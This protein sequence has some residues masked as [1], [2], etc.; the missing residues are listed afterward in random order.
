MSAEPIPLRPSKIRCNECICSS[1]CLYKNLSTEGKEVWQQTGT[2]QPLHKGDVL[3]YQGAPRRTI[4]II[5]SGNVKEFFNTSAGHEQILGFYSGGSAVGLEISPAGTYQNTSVALDTSA[6]CQIPY[7]VALNLPDA[8]GSI[9]KHLLDLSYER[10]S[11]R[12]EHILTIGQKS[13]ISRLA[14][15]L[16]DIS[17]NLSGRGFSTNKFTL[18]MCRHDIAN[19]LALAVETVSRAFTDLESSGILCVNRKQVE[20]FEWDL[21]A[22]IASGADEELLE[23]MKGVI[24][25]AHR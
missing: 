10:L 17:A 22:S 23:D 18:A 8:G 6:V 20:I 4:S 25:M 21:L 13:A 9:Q 12:N 19:Y 2:I 14:W 1:S 7:D 24:R 3:Y 5:K 11:S 16:L 15:L